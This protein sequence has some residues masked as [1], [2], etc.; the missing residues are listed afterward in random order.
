MPTYQTREEYDSI[1]ALNQSGAKELLKSPA[2]Y[3][4]YIN[5]DE[6]EPSKALRL[7]SYIHS[8][9][10]EGDEVTQKRY[11]VLPEGI[12]RRT[13]DGKA[14]Y[15]A[16]MKLHADATILTDDEAQTGAS[17][18]KAVRAKMSAMGISF[19]QTEVMFSV[20][21]EP[22]VSIK[23]AIDAI[24]DDGYLY[25]IKT[26]EDASSAGFLSA[27]RSYRYNL[28][29][30]FYLYAHS[31]WSGQRAKGFRFIAVE[32]S[33][34]YECA[35]YELGTELMAYALIDFER[36]LTLYRSCLAF[37]EYPGYPDEV[38]TIDIKGK[39]TGFTIA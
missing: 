15:E 6:A 34:P 14:A 1:T 10:L 38:Q 24:G 4:A 7:G 18:A 13:K 5:R 11:A 26:T 23:S 12:D 33:A 35:V 29:A 22:G 27:V 25:D 19:K 32:K 16:F 3:A 28:Q 39:Q 36:A 17:V 21:L 2:H 9:V 8:I 30:Y 20:E 31:L 37:G